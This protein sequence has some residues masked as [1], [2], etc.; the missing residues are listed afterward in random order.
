MRNVLVCALV[1]ILSLGL[2]ISVSAQH[3]EQGWSVYRDESA[4]RE[5]FSLLNMSGFIK[6]RSVASRGSIEALVVHIDLKHPAPLLCMSAADWSFDLRNK[7]GQ[8]IASAPN[9]SGGNGIPLPAVGEMWHVAATPGPYAG[10]PYAPRL[11]ADF[12]FEL[13]Q[14]Y[15]NLG[16]GTY[17]LQ[18]TFRPS[19]GS[20]PAT[21][22]PPITFIME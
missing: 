4:P 21:T 8:T 16:P 13:D 10:C 6:Y 15:P 2:P 5:S 19:D 3:S 7:D 22:L 11:D 12:P 17:R 9:I 18:I 14:I 1:S 20:V